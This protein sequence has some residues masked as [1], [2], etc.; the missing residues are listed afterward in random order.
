MAVIS[1]NPEALEEMLAEV[2]QPVIDDFGQQIIDV[3]QPPVDTGFL[4]ASAYIE[5][6]ATS[7]YA[8]TWTTGEYPDR[9]GQLVPR[10]QTPK[11]TPSELP[12]AI[13]GWA[14]EHALIIEETQPFIYIALLSA[15]GAE[16]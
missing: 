13:V 11:I 4:R 16:S 12:G 1:W 8:D 3:A 5:S 6:P 7:T 2:V 10:V 15:A 14:A 9:A